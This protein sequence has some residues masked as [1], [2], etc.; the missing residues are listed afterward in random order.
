MMI[1]FYQKT[2]CETDHV[3]KCLTCMTDNCNCMYSWF[4]KSAGPTFFQYPDLS[5]NYLFNEPINT[6][7]TEI[8]LHDTILLSGKPNYVYC[9]IPVL[10]D[11]NISKWRNYAAGYHD[12]KVLEFLEFGWPINFTNDTLPNPPQRKD[13]FAMNFEIDIDNYIAEELASGRIIGPFINN[14]FRIQPAIAPIFSVPKKEGGRRVIVDCSYGGNLSVNAGIQKDSFLGDEL[15]LQYPRH[16]KFIELLW[17]YGHGCHMFKIDLSKAFRQFPIDPRDY[18]LQC[19]TW[20]D[21]IYIDK[22]L[23]FGMRSSPQ[24]C[25][26]T[27]NL[28]NFILSR[29]N[30]ETINYLDDFGGVA[31]PDRAEICYNKTLKIFVELGLKISEKKCSPPNHT[32]VFLGKEYNTNTMTVKI[33]DQKLIE[34]IETVKNFS[35]RKKCTK[36]QLQQLVGK[37]AFAAECVR[38]GRLFISRMLATLRKYNFN[39]YRIYLDSEFHNDIKWWIS[40]LTLLMG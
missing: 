12:S 1:I 37:L 16:D 32:M 25:Q 7:V 8:L 30:I 29:Q 21:S 40:F 35:N 15:T 31:S 2:F 26:R 28:V 36:R 34:I 24:A 9:H 39:H 6:F 3:N 10:T 14:P 4:T 33:P 38:G 11:L 23:I 27:T 17:K 18:F 22:R 19:F 13:S 20:K 5:K